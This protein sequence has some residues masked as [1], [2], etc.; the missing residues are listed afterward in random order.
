[1][2]TPEEERRIMRRSETQRTI[3]T[4]LIL[5]VFLKPHSRYMSLYSFILYTF[6]PSE[7][8]YCELKKTNV[9]LKESS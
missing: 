2:G 6:S 8:F 1:M 7:T 9:F 4:T 3:S 5:I